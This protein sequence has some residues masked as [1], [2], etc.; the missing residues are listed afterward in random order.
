MEL[1]RGNK[2]IKKME[3]TVAMIGAMSFCIIWQQCVI[4]EVLIVE[5]NG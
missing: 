5:R 3:L 4:A 2:K 1:I